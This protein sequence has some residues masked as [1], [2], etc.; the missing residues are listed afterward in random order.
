LKGGHRKANGVLFVIQV[1]DDAFDDA[2]KSGAFF[3]KHFFLHL[4][5]YL[6]LEQYTSP[7]GCDVRRAAARRRAFAFSFLLIVARGHKKL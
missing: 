4:Q 3:F 6:Y 7:R 1:T 2:Q 5:V